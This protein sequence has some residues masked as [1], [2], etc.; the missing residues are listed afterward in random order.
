MCF[1]AVCAII[2]LPQQASAQSGSGICVMDAGSGRILY[3]SNENARLEMAS[4]TKIMTAIVA[5]D[6]L[7][8]S[9]EIR[10]PSEAVGVE[11]SSIYLRKGEIWT[12]KDL[13]YGLMLR[14]GN[15]A[16][17]A[18]AIAS[19]GNVDAFVAKMNEKAREFGLQDTHF[20]NPHGLHA[21]EH[22]T[23][24]RELAIIASHAMKIP[25][26]A[27]AVS[28]KIYTVEQNDTHTVHYFANKNKLLGTFDGA[29]GI[30]TGY[31]TD[32]G[33]CLVSAARR[34]GMQLIGVVLN[35]YNMWQTSANMLEKAFKGYTSVELVKPN[36]PLFSVNNGSA[37]VDLQVNEE[38]RYP[39]AQGESLDF[40]FTVRPD[41]HLRAPLAK[42]QNIGTLQVYHGN[43]LIFSSK[44]ST[45]NAVNDTGVVLMLSA[46]CGNLHIE[47]NGG[48]IEQ[49]FSVE[50][51]SIPPW[52][53][54]I[55]LTG[56]SQGQR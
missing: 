55:D 14:S 56:A 29:N 25:A 24:A 30:K 9:D 34:N 45:M 44:L 38:I 11:G 23:T 47:N 28:T 20:C 40:S 8:L 5:L 35:C 46:L 26:F 10:I 48:E 42:G 50:R 51:G 31:T 49:I 13:L 7:A 4:T 54:G 53:R 17:V 1:L 2:G 6:H 15:D 3:A 12:A 19:C 39:I 22:Y 18:L 33:R 27:E 16:A 37:C 43:R 41:T 52:G 36:Q 21:D 32:S